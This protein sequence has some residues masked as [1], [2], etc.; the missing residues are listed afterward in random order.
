M[1]KKSN[2]NLGFFLYNNL[3]AKHRYLR[4]SRFFAHFQPAVICGHLSFVK[5]ENGKCQ[6]RHYI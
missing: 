1:F 3:Q 5:I 4:V 2:T 6:N